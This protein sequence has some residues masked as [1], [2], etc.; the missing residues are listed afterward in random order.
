[1]SDKSIFMD[2]D[3]NELEIIEFYIEEVQGDQKY[4]GYYGIN[5]AKVLEIIRIPPIVAMPNQQHPSVLGSFNLRGKV[6]PLINLG[7]C[8]DKKMAESTNDKVIVCE[9]SGTVSAFVVSGVNHIH[10]LSWSQVERPDNYLQAFSKD[11][12]TGVVRIHDRILFLLD[13]EHIIAG[14]TG[15]GSH[16]DILKKM[17]TEEQFGVG[18]KIFVVDDSQSVRRL[19]SKILKQ[20]GFE[21]ELSN[22]GKEAWDTLQAYRNQVLNEGVNLQSLVEVVVSDIEMPEMDG[23][24]LLK[25]I[26]SDNILQ[27]LPVVL[28]SS[29]ITEALR[30]KGQLFGADDQVGKPDLPMLTDRIRALLEK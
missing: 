4:Q 26:K 6:L 1:M 19:M 10:R 20:V 27:K 16:E 23:H 29:H 24:T 5:V 11:S 30:K 21:I 13:M 12:I 9:F 14:M 28:F 18:H 25:N 8:L 22:T 3:S 17:N 2:S 7:I 15:T